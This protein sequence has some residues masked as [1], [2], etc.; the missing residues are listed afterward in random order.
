MIP[1][2]RKPNILIQLLIIRYDH[3]TF[4]VVNFTYKHVHVVALPVFR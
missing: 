2:L 3:Q 4:Y 1:N